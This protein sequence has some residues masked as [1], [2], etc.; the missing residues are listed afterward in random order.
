MLLKMK[1]AICFSLLF[2][3]LFAENTK[4]LTLT[5]ETP[6]NGFSTKKHLFQK[7]QANEVKKIAPV[8]MGV[9][10]PI[11]GYLT[12]DYLCWK[13]QR[14]NM[15]YAFSLPDIN[16]DY[17]LGEILY[18]KAKWKSGFRLD[19][20]FSN[21][22]DWTI[23]T[24]LTYYHNNSVTHDKNLLHTWI[25]DSSVDNINAKVQ[26]KITLYTLDLEFGSSFNCGKTVSIDPFISLRTAQVKHLVN[27]HLTGQ[28]YASSNQNYSTAYLTK[29]KFLGFGPRIGAKWEYRIGRTGLDIFSLF[30]A[31]L[32]YGKMKVDPSY[33]NTS[34]FANAHH[35]PYE[36]YFQ[37][38]QDLKATI[39]LVLG[40]QWKYYWDHDM[41]SFILRF[42]WEANYWFDQGAYFKE[43]NNDQ[44]SLIFSGLNIGIGFEY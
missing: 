4:E 20:N 39:Q 1:M 22:Y 8:N 25:Y 2:S 37:K 7:R 11:Y 44:R 17:S 5:N 9:N 26:S 24:V 10:N 35:N 18:G 42:A 33:E 32:L 27:L 36:N 30:S 14:T 41:K 3:C 29:Q 16:P 21:I 19:L 15:Y 23:G 31:S 40:S 43:E 38:F 12:I 34:Y 6:V 28:V 13:A